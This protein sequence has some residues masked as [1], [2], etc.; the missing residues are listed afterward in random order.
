MSW[1]Y[2]ATVVNSQVIA[3][4]VPVEVNG[5][6]ATASFVRTIVEARPDDIAGKTLTAALPQVAGPDITDGSRIRV[7][8][9]IVQPEEA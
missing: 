6:Q 8:I 9:E 2:L 1:T 5:E 3:Q 4:D 7:T